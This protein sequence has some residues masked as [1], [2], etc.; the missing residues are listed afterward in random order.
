MIRIGKIDCE[1]LFTCWWGVWLTVSP[2]CVLFIV[3]VVSQSPV[4]V[5]VDLWECAYLNCLSRS[6]TTWVD[7]S[8]S[9]HWHSHSYQHRNMWGTNQ[10]DLTL[11]NKKHHQ[12]V[13]SHLAASVPAPDSPPARL[14]LFR[15]VLMKGLKEVWPWFLNIFVEGGRWLQFWQSGIMSSKTSKISLLT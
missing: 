2:V 12:P 6:R 8:W 1:R 5:P 10:W 7:Q 4:C 3:I 14:A 11:N 13:S 15:I 9:T